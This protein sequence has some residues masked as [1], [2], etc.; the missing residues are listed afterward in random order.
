MGTSMKRTAIITTAVAGAAFVG[1]TYLLRRQQGPHAIE[2]HATVIPIITP[3][4]DFRV[5]EMVL[6]AMEHLPGEELTLVL[7]TQGGCVLSCVMI[8]NGL[9]RFAASTAVVPYMAISGGTLIALNATRLEM[10]RN[11]ALSAVDPI[12][13]GVRVKYMPEAS[14]D[15]EVLSARDYARSIEDYLRTTLTARQ[16]SS[17]PLAVVNRAMS[18]L[19]GDHTP[20]EWPITMAEV[21]QLGIPVEAAPSHWAALVDEYRKRWWR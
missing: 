10:G 5:A 21:A 2:R 17:A 6:E 15:T 8:A 18:R 16:G 12:V 14:Q 3:V 1:A 13:S 9:R 7:H 19:M 11:A 4:I 20:H